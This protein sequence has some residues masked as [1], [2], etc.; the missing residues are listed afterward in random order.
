MEKKN[1]EP[2]QSART[3]GRR[4]SLP[5][6]MLRMAPAVG[7]RSAV[8]VSDLPGSYGNGLLPPASSVQVT[9]SQACAASVSS[10]TS[11][12]FAVVLRRPPAS[13]CRAGTFDVLV[14]LWLKQFGGRILRFRVRRLLGFR[15]QRAGRTFGPGDVSRGCGAPD[16]SREVCAT[17]P[18]SVV[19]S[20][21][22]SS[23]KTWPGPPYKRLEIDRP[24][25][26]RDEKQPV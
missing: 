3:A 5:N 24:Q 6:R 14:L 4:S 9:P 17:W 13:R 2:T 20:P 8:T 25:A 16:T 10:K 11:S 1:D 12:G 23:P 15:P 7:R 21:V 18:S 26:A 22:R 19:G